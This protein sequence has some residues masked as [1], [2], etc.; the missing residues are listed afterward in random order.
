MSWSA[1]TF[2]GKPSQVRNHKQENFLEGVQ[3][4]HEMNC[5]RNNTR[6]YFKPQNRL[7]NGRK[8]L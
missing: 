5:K 8:S 7:A 3:F 2:S 4:K 1:V 6:C